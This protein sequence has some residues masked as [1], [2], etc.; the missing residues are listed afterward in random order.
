MSTERE[1]ESQILDAALEVFLRY[2][3]KKATMGDIAKKAGMSR[4]SLYLVFSNKE[5][6]FRAAITRKEEEF[7]EDT[8]RKLQQQS[9][10]QER[11]YTVLETWLLEPYEMI[12]TSPESEELLSFAY[13][14]APDLRRQMLE[15]MESQILLAM[16][17]VNTKKPISSQNGSKLTTK[18][19]S[20]LI[21]LSTVEMKHSV[22][23][24]KELRELLEAT[25][26][27]YATHL[28]RNVCAS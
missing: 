4:P 3:F 14:F 16:D 26:E 28:E 15:R 21:A 24:A 6:I 23:D 10:L 25:A 12:R 27:I 19:L 1:K 11:L 2:G 20:R 5:D 8:E 13:T 22:Q 7:C 17:V 18:S 9:G